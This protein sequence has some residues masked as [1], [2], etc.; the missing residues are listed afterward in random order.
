MV[1]LRT[2]SQVGPFLPGARERPS[3][4]NPVIFPG[5]SSHLTCAMGPDHGVSLLGHSAEECPFH[6]P[7]C[8]EGLTLLL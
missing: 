6:G 4:Q 8:Q 3:S 7:Y 5:L 2:S 1:P